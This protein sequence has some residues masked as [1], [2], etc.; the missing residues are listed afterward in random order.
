MLLEQGAATVS[1]ISRTGKTDDSLSDKI[2]RYTLQGKQIKIAAIDVC[3]PKALTA[4]IMDCNQQCGRLRGIIHAAGIVDDALIKD[5]DEKRYQQT[6]HVKYQGLRNLLDA[7]RHA[8]PDFLITYSSASVILGS[9]GQISYVSANAAMDAII[10][11]RNR[12][13]L[14]LSLIHI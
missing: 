2:H 8:E 11:N 1:I 7:I 12:Q 14:P 10:R 4:W 3:D 13:G 6:I 9:P 5:M